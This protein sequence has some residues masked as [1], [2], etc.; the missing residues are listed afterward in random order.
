MSLYLKHRPDSLDNIK[1]NEELVNSLKNMLSKPATCPHVFMLTGPSGC[2]KTTI[3]RI[4]AKELNISKND[5]QE[6]NS[7]DFRGIDTIR[8][9]IKNSQ[10]KP[11]SGKYRMFLMDEV[12]QLSKDAQN[13][14]LKI[15]EDTP[16]H[17]FFVL[18]TTDPVKLLATVKNR[19]SQFAVKPISDRE[20]KSLLKITAK[21]EGES[22]EIE[23]LNQIVQDSQG[24][25]RLAL[26]ILEQVLNTD[27]DKRLEAA[28]QIAEQ[29]SEVISLCRA[30]LS[31]SNW[32]QIA[33]IL[34]GLKGQE[35]E[36]IRRI[37]LGYAQ[38]V[39]LKTDNPKAGLILEEFM[40]PTYNSGFP[41]VVFAC[42]SIVKNS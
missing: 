16:S 40:E 41:Q 29:E 36:S 14:L 35:P 33:A 30:L 37:V 4:I 23:V 10:Y 27:P 20:M 9:I 1:G 25:S 38:A 8:E 24:H 2:G 22:L 6:I 7:S 21:E 31:N 15:L 18:C 42:Y 28:R 39:L 19:C 11:I 13:A 34:Q 12:H 26:Q 32:K 5:L 3:G 17:V